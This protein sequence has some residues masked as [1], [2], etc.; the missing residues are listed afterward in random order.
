MDINTNVTQS[1]TPITGT[2]ASVTFAAELKQLLALHADLKKHCAKVSRGE[3]WLRDQIG[4]Y[5]QRCARLSRDN[6][7]LHKVWSDA[8]AEIHAQ[9]AQE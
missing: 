1:N 5:T 9:F 2:Y 3:R 4:E 7:A 8:Q 6:P